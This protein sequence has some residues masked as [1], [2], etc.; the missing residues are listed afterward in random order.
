[1]DQDELHDHYEYAD[2]EIYKITVAPSPLPNASA[3][4][5]LPI[6]KPNNGRGSPSLPYGNSACRPQPTPTKTAGCL[7]P[8]TAHRGRFTMNSHTL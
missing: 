4:A 8:V 5:S 3:G 6:S 2:S 1:M 7:S